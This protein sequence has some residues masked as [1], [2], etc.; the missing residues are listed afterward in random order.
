MNITRPLMVFLLLISRCYAQEPAQEPPYEDAFSDE[1]YSDTRPFF[2]VEA[3]LG[4]Q[5]LEHVRFENGESDS[6]R[7]GSGVYIALGIAHLMFN[8]KMDVG[9]KGGYLFDLI[10]AKNNAGETSVLS[11]TRKP[12]DVFSHYWIGRHCW[13]GGIS[14]HFDP[15]FTSRE[16]TDNA[17]YHTAY[18]AYAEYLFHF[19]G[20]GSSLGLKYLNISYK[21]KQNDKVRDGSAWGISFNQLF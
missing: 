21:N 10:T 13:G 17:R 15:T 12:I 4:G 7:A 8:K 3:L 5:T 9:I 14:A 19:P 11:F 20:T 1:E 18:G 2:S 6:I 16:T